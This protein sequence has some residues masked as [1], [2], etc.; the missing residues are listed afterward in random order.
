MVDVS[1]YEANMLVFVDETGV[2]RRDSLM[3]TA[4]GGSHNSHVN[5]LH[6]ESEFQ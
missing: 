1:L 3:D 6:E 2:D 5:V 4:L